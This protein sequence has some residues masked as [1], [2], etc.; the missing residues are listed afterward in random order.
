[1]LS[2]P[3]FLNFVLVLLATLVSLALARL[4]T[5]RFESF[6]QT[7]NLSTSASISHT[8]ALYLVP[9]IISPPFCQQVYQFPIL[10]RCNERFVFT[11]LLQVLGNI[12]NDGR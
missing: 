5:R 11:E 8:P 4:V 3:I 2:T 7:Q 1:M 12:A 10:Q 9:I 6:F